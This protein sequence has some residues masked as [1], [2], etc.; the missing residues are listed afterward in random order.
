MPGTEKRTTA[1]GVFIDRS[2]A[3]RAVDE[4]YR[5]GFTQDQIGYIIPND[6]PIVEPPDLP[7]YTMTGEGAVAGAGAGGVIGGLV[8]LALAAVMVPGLGPFIL[9]GVLAGAAAGITGGGLVGALI[10]MNIP[11]EEAH[12]YDHHLRSGRTLVTVQAGE[13]YDEAAAALERATLDVEE[14]GVAHQQGRRSRRLDAE[15]EPSFRGGTF[16]APV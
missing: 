15:G 9:G 12:R 16:I 1:V 4:L 3:Q 2:H 7:E 11:E 10:G 8:G 14:G 13:R 5:L 6:G